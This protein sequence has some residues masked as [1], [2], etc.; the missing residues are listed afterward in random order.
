MW[1]EKYTITTHV[2]EERNR[3]NPNRDLSKS[4]TRAKHL[5]D[6]RRKDQISAK[7]KVA[8]LDLMCLHNVNISSA[9]HSGVGTCD[10]AWCYHH[11]ED[12]SQ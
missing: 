6:T 4:D 3:K 5:M 9:R 8:V 11:L 12:V 10:N 7:Q 1:Q 2:S